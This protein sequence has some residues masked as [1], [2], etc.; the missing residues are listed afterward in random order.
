MKKIRFLAFIFI[1]TF[2]LLLSSCGDDINNVEFNNDL[3]VYKDSNLNYN[4]IAFELSNNYFEYEDNHI[5][6]L[7][8]DLKVKNNTKDDISIKLSNSK[9][10]GNDLELEEEILSNYNYSNKQDNIKFDEKEIVIE[11]NKGS[12]FKF[13]LVIKDGNPICKYKLEFKINNKNMYLH[14][15]KEGYELSSFT[16]VHNPSLNSSALADAVYDVNAVFGY[17]PSENG[18]LSGYTIYD[19]T[20]KDAVMEYKKS[21]IEY[22][23]GNDKRISELEN[24]LRKENKSIEEIAKECSKLRNEIRL[25]AYKD[26]SEGLA[27]VKQRNLEKYGHEDGPTP[28]ELYQKYGT[29][30]LVLEKCYSS[31]Y[32]MDACCGVYDLYFNMYNDFV[33]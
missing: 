29:W 24:R 9:S 13:H 26:D 14:S 10:Y 15:Y 30:E 32:G 2:I 16:Y 4:D 11:K 17:K 18:S 12:N 20:D 31:N 1:C 27:I 22:V 5:L 6:D 8:F 25:E 7:N 3:N 19:W 28:E 23:D 33:Y 21:R